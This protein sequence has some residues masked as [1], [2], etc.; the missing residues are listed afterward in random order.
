M[1]LRKL[2]RFARWLIPVVGI[3]V[4]AILVVIA[5]YA[6]GAAPS[7]STS[8]SSQVVTSSAAEISQAT[9]PQTSAAAP[10][11]DQDI[12]AAASQDVDADAQAADA[13]AF[14]SDPDFNDPDR[15]VRDLPVPDED[16]NE[17]EELGKLELFWN[18]RLTYPT[19]NFDS[20]WV[21]EAAQ[22]N[23]FIP[24]GVPAG[25]QRANRVGA[26]SMSTSGFTA[27]GP[28]PEHMT[29][30]SGCYDYGTTAGRINAIVIDPVTT[31]NGSI[32]AYSAGVGGGV[33]KT[34][35]CCT[36][37]TTWFAT[38]DDPLLAT[39]S[40]DTLAMDPQDH[41]TIYA[42]TGDLNYGSFSMGSQG[43]LKSTDAG[44]TWTLLGADIFTMPLPQ[45]AGEFP[46]YNA[47]G[48][49][50]VDPRNSNNVVAGTKTGLYFSYDAGET[51]TGPCYTNEYSTTMRQDITGLELSDMGA[52]TRIVA[53]V[54]VR[55]FATAVQYNL[56]WNGA[57]GL[58]RGTIPASGCPTD[59]T[60]VTRNDNGFIFGTAVTGSP[61]T[62]GANMNAGSGDVYSNTTTGNQ[63]G[64]IDIAVAPSN[65]A[66]I[67]AQVQSI[68]PNSNSGCGNSSGCQLGTWASA[69]GGDTWTFMTGSAGGS[70][71]NC[72]NGQGD[73]PQNW[74]DQG[75][76]VDPNDPD[77]LFADTFEVWFATRTGT[78]WYNLTCGYNGG[79]LANHVVHVDQHALAFL[80]G[81]S[82]IL[83]AGNDGGTHGAITV[84]QVLSGTRPTW[85]N[86]DGGYN[87][88]EF[89]SGDISGDFA[90]SPN[91]VAVGGAQDNG[92]SSV[93]FNGSPTGPVQWQMGLGGDGFYA[94]LDPVGGPTQAQG[95]MALSSTLAP[96]VGQTFTVSSQMFTWVTTRT[97]TGEVSLGTS[98]TTRGNNIVAAVNTDI[99]DTVTS[100]RSGSNVIVTAITP[101]P[102]G[103]SIVFD[104]GTSD[105]VT[106]D[107]NG[108]LGGRTLGITNSLRLFEGNNSGGMSRCVYNC[109][110][111]SASWSSV[112]GSWTGD[113]QAFQL[114]FDIF[115][116][117][118]SGGD[119]C[120][121]AGVPGGCGHLIAG[122]TRVWE[123][124]SGGNATMS[125][126]NWYIT[127][128]PTT[129]NMSKQTLG[130]RSYINQ[131]KYSPKYQS[132]AIAGTND[133]NVWI[134]FNLGTGVASEANWVDVTGGNTVLPNRPVL[135]IALDPSAASV[136]LP[137]GYAAVGGF[138]ENTPTMPGHV[139]RVTCDTANC[140]TFTW[141][142]KTGNL[143]NIPVDSII[144]NPNYPQ[145]VYAG[146]DWGLYFTNDVN[147]ASPL[148]YRFDN[149]LPHAM[150]WDMQIDRGATALSVWTRGR[151]AYAYP[152]PATNITFPAT[153]TLG[154]LTQTYN[155]TP[156]IATA[157]TDPTGLN[158]VFT[159]NGSSTPPTDAGVYTVTGTINDLTYQGTTTGT[160]TVLKA[161]TTMSLTSAPNP[162]FFGQA[163]TFTT[164]VTANAPGG[165]TPTGS[166]T[167]TIDSLSIS[168]SLDGN[169]QAVY[170]TD[171]LT[172]GSH[173]AAAQY[174]GAANFNGSSDTLSGGQ[175]VNEMSITG[176]TASSSSPTTIHATT[177]LT[178]TISAGTNV[179]YTWNFGDGQ[180]GSGAL[181][182]HQYGGIGTYTATVTA[183]NSLGSVNAFTVVTIDPLKVY[184]PLVM[185]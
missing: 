18:D 13:D 21:R 52:S 102:D 104:P 6:S 57:N 129:Q 147:A 2:S 1:K 100:A 77:R 62:T 108:Y 148:W 89:Y 91:P 20:A 180:T 181:T 40:I 59:F 138:N 152:L 96:T 35:D 84:S 30:C 73:Y 82:D 164:T 83:L 150:I 105:G 121:P 86:M 146:T 118:I 47:V 60:L 12:D 33:W 65:P 98:T 170:V 172:L 69:D 185:K 31:T 110:S 107:G 142:D 95:T 53:A 177:A 101:G 92:P 16:E 80:P 19:G 163:V 106:M 114:P 134:G 61:Y 149:G 166:I 169:G 171:T 99:S 79:S 75:L 139:F 17:A 58:Y 161:D 178:A 64:R 24:A 143:P 155:G 125:G 145:Q 153:V 22:Q 173:S 37:S 130:N 137:V 23:A 34:T 167:L 183:T 140:A 29:G 26:L 103:N 3:V 151:G 156:R 45:P 88:I 127:N 162:V 144:V 90:N 49:V 11:V 38:T 72:T 116:G 41:N 182:S 48:K 51:W 179:A 93:M 9:A 123:T 74:Y 119:D 120:A 174:D 10:E 97:V 76:A 70:L 141:Q 109:T 131:V 124:V 5:L 133:A 50:R 94:R 56:G 112:R 71:R 4:V 128:N 66:Y 7:T 54:G 68:A 42:G 55:G 78:G 160:L 27:L 176:L 122:T 8:N 113:T 157:T 46:Q 136:D 44:A 87:T 25:V 115:R 81:S 63:L 168:V 154:S 132:V 159:Y 36:D 39:I 111:P 67:Y 43:V 135:G 158:V 117:G 14:M 28:M 184:L 32:V 165:G 126:S 85:F 175:V 15:M